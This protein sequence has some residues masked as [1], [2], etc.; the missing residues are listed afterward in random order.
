MSVNWPEIGE[1]NP[2]GFRSDLGAPYRPSNGMDIAPDPVTKPVDVTPPS[3]GLEPTVLVQPSINTG[4]VRTL[5]ADELRAQ[6][7]AWHQ[8]LQAQ[9]GYEPTD[10]LPEAAAS[11]DARPEV[12]AAMDGDHLLGLGDQ[13]VL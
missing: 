10:Q 11:L 5:S 6:I 12:H 3:Q 1:T 8:A 13:Y 9:N 2:S 7:A 4:T